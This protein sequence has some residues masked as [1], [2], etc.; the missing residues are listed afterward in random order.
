MRNDLAE[1]VGYCGLIL[2][3]YGQ[4]GEPEIAYEFLREHWGQGF[5]TEAA[6]AVIA[7][8]ES[9]GLTRLWATVREWNTPS[10]AVMRKLGFIETARVQRDAQHGD[11]L[12]YLLDLTP[13][14]KRHTM[15]P[16]TPNRWPQPE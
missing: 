5:A 12:F 16:R 9:A 11:S 6:R 13:I 4:E 7:W 15:P 14:P 10:R 8:A 1:E 2:H 3:S